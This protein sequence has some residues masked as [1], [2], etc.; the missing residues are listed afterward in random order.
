[1]N[2]VVS[3]CVLEVEAYV[4]KL[5]IMGD[6]FR[7]EKFKLEDDDEI[8]VLARLNFSCF[9]VGDFDGVLAASDSFVKDKLRQT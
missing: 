2:C 8:S 1:M 6:K 7:G 4:F 3:V 5:P 9:C